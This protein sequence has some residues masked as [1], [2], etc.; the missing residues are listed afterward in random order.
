M[1]FVNSGTDN[2]GNTEWV[3]EGKNCHAFTL[4]R[5]AS[6]LPINDATI[7]STPRGESSLTIDITSNNSNE[8][9]NIR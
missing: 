4:T 3:I 2:K 5:F 9:G 6:Y 1:I 7:L 8:K